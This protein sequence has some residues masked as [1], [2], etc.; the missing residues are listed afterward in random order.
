MIGRY[1]YPLVEV[2]CLSYSY[3]GGGPGC[4]HK[5]GQ[6][7]EV[8]WLRLLA[9]AYNSTDPRVQES[10]RKDRFPCWTPE[11]LHRLR[12]ELGIDDARGRP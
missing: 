1:S 8:E 7:V 11:R 9:L 3:R 10:A 5:R 2:A 4:S 6:W 12:P